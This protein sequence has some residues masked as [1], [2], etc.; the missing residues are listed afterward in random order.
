M[1]YKA[2]GNSSGWHDS[3]HLFFT[4]KLSLEGKNLFPQIADLNSLHANK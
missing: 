4:P 2:Q 1:S 3:R